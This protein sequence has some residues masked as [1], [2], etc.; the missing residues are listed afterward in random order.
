[1][2]GIDDSTTAEVTE[3][4]KGRINKSDFLD[5][6]PLV[7]EGWSA[8]DIH[9]IG[10]S[11]YTL[12]GTDLGYMSFVDGYIF[13][14]ELRRLTD[15]D[16][17]KSTAQIAD[18]VWVDVTTEQN[19]CT[20]EFQKRDEGK[21]RKKAEHLV[22]YSEICPSIET[23]ILHYWDTQSHDLQEATVSPFVDG[24]TNR[25][26]TKFPAPSADVL[27]YESVFQPTGDG[28]LALKNFRLRHEF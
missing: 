7:A 10:L 6:F 20:V 11:Y 1:M 15:Q 26:G 23:L 18:S 16:S 12:L 28:D 2:V 21:L 13:D 14:R 25:K 27:V 24:H 3:T 8:S 9:S 5:Q 4:I 17:R 19:I 22:E